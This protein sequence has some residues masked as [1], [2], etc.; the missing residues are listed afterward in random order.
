M[1]KAKLS[2]KASELEA[3]R[4]ALDFNDVTPTKLFQSGDTVKVEV[5]FSDASQLFEAGK[6]LAT[7]KESKV[8][9][10][11]TVQKAPTKDTKEVSK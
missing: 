5:K 3:L 11:T 4:I 7:A 2:V 10:F 6:A 1:A 9:D 8:I